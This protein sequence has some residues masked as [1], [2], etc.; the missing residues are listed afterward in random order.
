MR[1]IILAKWI[2]PG[3]FTGRSQKWAYDP[4]SGA[5]HRIFAM[6]SPGYLRDSRWRDLRRHAGCVGL[7]LTLVPKKDSIKKNFKTF[8]LG[9]FR[10]KKTLTG[11]RT[12]PVS[13]TWHSAWDCDSDAPAGG[14]GV[15]AQLSLS[16]PSHCLRVFFSK[17]GLVDEKSP[18]LAGS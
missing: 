13:V 12:I 15:A 1:R 8:F 10:F 7:D 16:K 17:D 11:A 6:L 3:N 14:T 5:K 4:K 18:R 9:N 2:V